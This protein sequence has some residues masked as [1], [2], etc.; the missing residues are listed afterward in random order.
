MKKGKRD[1]L[2]IRRRVIRYNKALLLIF[3]LFILYALL[4]TVAVLDCSGVDFYNVTGKVTKDMLSCG[5]MSTSFFAF[6]LNNNMI[7]CYVLGILA[8]IFMVL[9]KVALYKINRIDTNELDEEKVNKLPHII[10]TLFLGYTGLHKYRTRNNAIGNIYFVNFIVF[11]VSWF[12]KTFFTG[13]YNNYSIFYCTYKFSLLFLIGI[14]ILNIVE[15]IFSFFSYRDD[16]DR[17]FA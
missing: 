16:E 9:Q 15:A 2:R 8:L 13:T 4:Y 10:I 3:G 14:I 5:N 6:I 1:F 7:I 12:I 17:I 11:I